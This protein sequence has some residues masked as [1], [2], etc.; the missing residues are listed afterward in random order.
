VTVACGPAADRADRPRPGELMRLVARELTASG[1]DVVPPGRDGGCRMSINSPAAR[2]ELSVTDWAGIEWRCRPQA[3]GGADPGQ[4]ADL[5]AT[6]LTGRAHDP[7]RRPGGYD[8][9]G[10]TFKGIVGLALK[11][12]GLDVA[13][14]V[15]ADA[16]CFDV[17]AEIVVTS[18]A[19]GHDA[20]VRVADDGSLTWTRDY[21]P[22]A[23]ATTWEPGFCGWIADPA[24]VAVAVVATI[25]AAM[26]QL[27]RAAR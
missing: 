23:A 16:D 12:R 8:R 5:A 13:L 19:T 18:P 24:G 9:E 27:A 20:A 17:W 1:C 2:C 21:W 7:A 4:V 11:A 3:A 22:E 25:T 26:S 6:L 14:E 10:L 15:C